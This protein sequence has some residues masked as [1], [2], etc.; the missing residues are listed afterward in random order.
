MPMILVLGRWIYI[1]YL[2]KQ[3]EFE[4][5][6]AIN[7]LEYLEIVAL[8]VVFGKGHED[9]WREVAFER[10]WGLQFW[11][12]AGKRKSSVSRPLGKWRLEVLRNLEFEAAIYPT[13]WG[14]EDYYNFWD[15]RE[16][17]K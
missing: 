1:K 8:A 3:M 7:F 4:F 5:A 14:E 10:W 12:K 6:R 2:L 9:F 11:K 15:M 17:S 13:R 16:G